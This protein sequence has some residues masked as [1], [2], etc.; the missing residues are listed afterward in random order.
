MKQIR[1]LEAVAAAGWGPAPLRREQLNNENIGPILEEVETGQRPK[2]KD[3]ADRCL[4]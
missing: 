3:I 2:W 4:T 1:A